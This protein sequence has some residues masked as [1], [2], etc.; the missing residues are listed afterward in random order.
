MF[1]NIPGTSGFQAALLALHGF[2][3]LALIYIGRFGLPTHGEFLHLKL[4]YFERATN[5]LL[6]HTNVDRGVGLDVMG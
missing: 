5:A 3:A 4:E 1:G 2:A 6:N